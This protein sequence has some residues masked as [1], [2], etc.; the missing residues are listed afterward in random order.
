M[1]AAF[2]CCGVGGIAVGYIIANS[3][4]V[5]LRLLWT[6]DMISRVRCLSIILPMGVKLAIRTADAL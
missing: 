2:S 1:A 5:K 3:C 4:G 6:V